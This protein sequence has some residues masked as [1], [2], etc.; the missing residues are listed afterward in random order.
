MFFFGSYIDH[1]TLKTIYLPL[2]N[3]KF[4]NDAL[5]YA[6][7]VRQSP[8]VNQELS[9]QLTQEIARQGFDSIECVV[10]DNVLEV[11]GEVP[12]RPDASLLNI[13]LYRIARATPSI[14]RVNL[15]GLQ[16]QR[17]PMAVQ[18]WGPDRLSPADPE[19]VEYRDEPEHLQAKARFVADRLRAA[20][21]LVVFTGA[22]ISTAAQ[23]PD[24]R[25][26]NG[27]WT[28][29]D[30]GL[31]SPQSVSL[32]DARP[33]YTHLALKRLQDEDVLK[34]LV[35]QNIDGLH[36]RSGIS[37]DRIAELHGNCFMERCSGCQ[38]EYLRD[39]DASHNRLRRAANLPDPLSQSGISH[40]TGRTCDDCGAELRDTIIHFKEDLPRAALETT[41]E[42]SGRADLILCM[43]TSLRVSPANQ[44][45]FVGNA[46]VVVV[47]LQCTGKDV[48][49]LRS[50]G[51]LVHAQ[52][53]EF[54]QMVM[55]ELGFDD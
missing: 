45:P 1:A 30:R 37:A 7:E 50:G 29:R 12:L 15:K 52:C 34:Y 4:K 36:R 8:Q 24:F 11:L 38:K 54:M 33:T 10:R 40:M 51:V 35:S 46:A 25:G 41:F 27:V 6:E 44:M 28:R 55:Q 43:G 47:N 53:D 20:R 2:V 17:P 32:E 31:P 23:I 3:A 48:P 26:P 14:Q 22:G 39:Y 21:H 49:A 9:L 42:H 19:L 13:A 5:D 16:Y 18:N